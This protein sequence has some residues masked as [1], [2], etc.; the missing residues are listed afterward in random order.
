MHIGLFFG[1]FNPIHIG[2][3]FIAN[4]IAHH[5]DLD[6]VWLVVSPQNPFKKKA[7]LLSEYDRLHLV[8]LAVE[9]ND[10]LKSSDIEFNLPQPSYTIDTLTY[11]HEKYPNDKFSLIMG[12][13][14]W[15]TIHKWKNAE[16]LL[17]NYDFYIFQRP[18]YPLKDKELP[19][20]VHLQEAPQVF[21]SASFIRQ[22]LKDGKPIQ[23]LV[24]DKV[25]K[26]IMESGWYR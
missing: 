12:S 4:H 25:A 5:S 19:K 20:N 6:Q 21:L 16:I 2:H 1:S 17:E 3:L 11:L 23:Y 26:Y 22:Q 7:S 24:H 15:P 14:N 8:N 13:D 10:K 18:D 9:D